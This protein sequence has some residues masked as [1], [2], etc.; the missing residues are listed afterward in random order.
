MTETRCF[1]FVS[2]TG[3]VALTLL[4]ASGCA[5]SDSSSDQLM[6]GHQ[7][8]TVAGPTVDTDAVFKAVAFDRYLTSPDFTRVSTIYPSNKDPINIAEWVS[9]SSLSQYLKFAPDLP[10]PN[11][12]MPVGTIIVRAVYG[13]PV[14]AAVQDQATQTAAKITLMVKGPPGYDPDLGDWWFAVTD[15]DGTPIPYANSTSPQ[16]GQMQECHSCHLMQ[17]TIT[18]DFMFGVLTTD[19]LAGLPTQ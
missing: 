7:G 13:T 14:D 16:Q 5:M 3:A 4:A 9:T 2:Y 6:G 15:R 18:N 17:R 19:R 1:S 8:A 11:T 12:L 10:A